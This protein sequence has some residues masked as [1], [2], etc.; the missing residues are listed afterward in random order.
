MRP[1]IGAG[2]PRQ[3]RPGAESV[4]ARAT[5]SGSSAVTCLSMPIQSSRR[6]PTNFCMRAPSADSASGRSASIASSSLRYP[7]GN[8]RPRSTQAVFEDSI[9]FARSNVRCR[10]AKGIA[11][12]PGRAKAD[13]SPSYGSANQDRKKILRK[14]D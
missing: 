6:S 11:P 10:A 14:T 8:M 2:L 7:L 4:R 9:P 13:S 5:N 3:Y 1:C 12:K